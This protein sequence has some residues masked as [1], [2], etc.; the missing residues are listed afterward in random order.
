MMSN[1]SCPSYRRTSKLVSPPQ[2][3][4]AYRQARHSI[5]KMRLG[6]TPLTEVK[7]PLVTLPFMSVRRSSKWARMALL[8]EATGMHV[9]AYSVD[10]LLNCKLPLE[11]TV[12]LVRGWP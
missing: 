2:V 1:R 12:T 3:E 9:L 11:L 6:S 10:E 5:L 4:A 8:N 7:M